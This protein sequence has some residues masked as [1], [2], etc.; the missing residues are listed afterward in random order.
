MLRKVLIL[1]FLVFIMVV[2]CGC[3]LRFAADEV[4]KQN[5]YLHKRVAEFVKS[6]SIEEGVSSEL[7]GLVELNELQSRVF[8]SD[9]GLPKA[10]PTASTIDEVLD[11]ENFTIAGAAME[12]SFR[13]PDTWSVA[14][15]F[16]EIGI[17]VAGLFGGV[18]GLKIA[19][20]LR[21]AKINSNALREIILGNEVFKK[22][23][24]QMAQSFKQA[25]LQQSK[26]TRKI[27]AEIQNS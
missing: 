6:A 1:V 10:L 25:H 23:N 17:A 16:I 20:V 18:W 12:S 5:A 22:T 14:D 13:K 19:S 2:L 4:Q 8:V 21:A 27:V 24:E 26:P 9:Y 7:A 3:G 11:E 15:G